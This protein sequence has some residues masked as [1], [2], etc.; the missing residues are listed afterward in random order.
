MAPQH[1]VPKA[2]ILAGFPKKGTI[3][4]TVHRMI[5]R[6][7]EAL[8]A[9]QGTPRQGAPAAKVHIVTKDL[10]LLPLTGE[11]DKRTMTSNTTTTGLTHSKPKR[12]QIWPTASTI[13]QRCINNQ[14][15]KRHKSDAHKVSVHLFIVEKKKPDGMS[16]GR[17]TRPSW[18]SMKL[19]QALQQ[20]LITHQRRD[21]SMLLQ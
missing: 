5:R 10:D 8:Q 2:M 7:L 4:E 18:Q 6:S 1:H 11:E 9:K 12:K 3:N 15:A 13:Q 21:L 14:V 20:S 17:C 16:I 19:A